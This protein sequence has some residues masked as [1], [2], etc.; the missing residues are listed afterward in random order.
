[1]NSIRSFAAWGLAGF[2][3]LLGACGLNTDGGLAAPTG[4]GGSSGYAGAAGLGGHAAGGAS[5]Q[6]GIAGNGGASG[7]GGG[8]GSQP[9]AS[10]DVGVG[11]AAQGGGAGT[12]GTPAEGGA[13]GTGGT[14]AEGGAPGTGGTPAEG[15]SAGSG[16]STGPET[17]CTNDTDDDGDGKVDCADDNCTKAGYVSLP[18]V[19]AGAQLYW[20]HERPLADGVPACPT[21]RQEG[22]FEFHAG[23]ATCD[24]GCGA[25]TGGECSTPVSIPTVTQYANCGGGFDVSA[26]NACRGPVPDGWT[27][28]GLKGGASTVNTKGACTASVK[29]TIATPYFSKAVDL[30]EVTETGTGAGAAGVCVPAAPADYGVKACALFDGDV[31]CSKFPGFTHPHTYFMGQTDTRQC[32]V[33]G[34]TCDPAATTCQAKMVFYSDDHCTTVL[35][36][37]PTKDATCVALNPAYSGGTAGSYKGEIDKTLGACPPKGAGTLSGS[38]EATGEKTLCCP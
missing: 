34:C 22:F 24:C 27:L 21:Q 37:Y 17:D 35:K 38:A 15:G 28:A 32:D 30:C 12:G 6:G 8:G 19:P 23:S 11:G 36:E 5:G 14:P 1:M 18:A 29:A 16:G 7:K 25:A 33:Q 20:F 13:P 10:D 2:V 9:D 31:D 4:A 3:G 26:W